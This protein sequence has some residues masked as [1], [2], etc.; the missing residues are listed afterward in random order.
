MLMCSTFSF[1][2][3]GL[4]ATRLGKLRLEL[5]RLQ[6]TRRLVRWGNGFSLLATAAVMILVVSFL[7][8]WLFDMSQAQRFVLLGLVIGGVVWA[9]RKY[10]RPWL[11]QKEDLV[12]LALQVEHRQGIDSDLVAAMQFEES[13]ARTWG[14]EELENAV[15]S[16]VADLSPQLNVFAGFSAADFRRRLGTA[17]GAAALLL[18]WYVVL[19]GYFEA[20]FQRLLLGAESYPTQTRIVGVRVNG[21]EVLVS[22]AATTV[23]CPYGSPLSF[24][25]TG[26]GELPA[27]GAG[28]IRI[29]SLNGTIAT[30]IEIAS[31]DPPPDSRGTA[32][33]SGQENSSSV[34]FRGELPRLMDSVSLRVYLGDARSPSLRVDAIPLPAVDVEIDVTP[35]EYAR[36]A[37][38]T[39]AAGTTSRRQLSVIEGSRVELTVQSLNKSLARVGLWIGDDQYDLTSSDNRKWSFNIAGTP[40]ESV[41]EPLKFRIEVT[42]SEGLELES[43]IH[44]TLRLKND[45]SP[46]VAVSL[47]TRKVI[48]T[49]APPVLWSASDDFGLSRVVAQVQ[50]A[51]V[52]G[53]VEEDEVEIAAARDGKPH[54]TS[55]RGEY[56]LDLEPFKLVKGDE[57]K[58]MFIAWDT[59][60]SLEPQKSFSEPLILSVT[61]QQGILSGL[62][63]TDEESA[64]Q[65]D[66]IIRRELGIG[67]KN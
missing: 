37:A 54:P 42:D 58:V 43:P 20:F 15:I 19:P 6:S 52:D 7:A 22:R 14:S 9:F 55:L 4:M 11:Q 1:R 8:D 28:R 53:D 50:V 61:D 59:R 63:Q 16:Q 29:E 12:E 45:Q 10:T 2:I 34:E 32:P 49:A 44:G 35:P 57:L 27:S 31:S 3:E 18:V 40:F 24:V 21:E 46:R 25:V 17:A 48:P 13:E 62:L 26:D 38:Q 64:K 41:S 47:R 65:L 5:G 51:R 39:E 60:G 67:E 36:D 66:A 23:S 30:D 56:H 33:V